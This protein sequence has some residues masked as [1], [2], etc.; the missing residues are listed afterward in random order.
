MAGLEFLGATPG[1]TGQQVDAKVD[2]ALLSKASSSRLYTQV[3]VMPGDTLTASTTA[4]QTFQSGMVVP[5]NTAVVGQAFIMKGAGT[6]TTN[7]VLPPTQR[8]RARLGG[9]LLVDAAAQMFP[10]SLASCRYRFEI[11]FIV[12]SLGTSGTVEAFGELTFATS[13]TTAIV[14]LC[15]PSGVA[16]DAGNPVTVNTTVDMPLTLSCQFGAVLAGNANSLRQLSVHTL[17]PVTGG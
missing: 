8:A 4:E 15:G 10:V 6:Y 9:S 1:L 2:A 7:A 3:A 12:R 16:G 11:Q 17:K 14:V 5:G 13:L